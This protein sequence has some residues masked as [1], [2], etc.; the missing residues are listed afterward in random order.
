MTDGGEQLELL[1]T[2]SRKR[3]PKPPEPPADDDPVAGVVLDVSLPHLD[4]VFDYVVPA[5]MSD[6]AVPGARVRARFAG[7]EV[8]GFVVER[9]AATEHPGRLT[10]LRR[11]ASAEPVL[12][13]QVLAA[14]R[15]VA[16]ACAGT[17]A[18]VLR[19]AVP[20]RHAASEKAAPT[21]RRPLPSAPQPGPWRD[22]AGGEAFLA[23]VAAGSDPRAVWTAMPGRGHDGW[24]HAVAVATATALA[25]GRGTAIVV[26]D[27]RDAAR[28]DEALTDVLG[29]GRHVQLAADAGVGPRYRAFLALLRGSVRVVVGT[30]AAAFAPVADLGLV[31]CWDDGDDLHAEPRAPYPHTREVLAVRA[32]QEGAAFL[33]G[34]TSRT[35]EAQQL[36]DDGWAREVVAVR[37][38]VRRRAPRVVVAGDDEERDP[39]ARAARLPSLALRVTRSALERGPVLVQV[40]RA[41]YLPAL[42]CQTCRSPAR[43]A[44]CHGPLGL[45][46]GRATPA[47]RWCGRLAGGWTCP[48]CEGQRLRSVTVGSGRTAEELGR[49]FPGTTVRS[50][51][52][53]G[54]VLARVPDS[55]ALVV[56]TPG[57]EPV[58]AAGYAAGLLLD[59][60]APLA[61][62]DLRAAE[63]ALRRWLQA[64]SL[65]RGA[66]EGGDVVLVGDAGLSVVQAAVRW[67]PAGHAARELVERAELALPPA[68]AMAEVRGIPEGVEALLAAVRLPAGAQVLGPVPVE[69]PR[70][71]GD[72]VVRALVRAP[73][74]DAPALAAALAAARALLSARKHPAPPRVHTRPVEVA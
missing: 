52:G 61:R 14:A 41:G 44:A 26:P 23:R 20:P 3:R 73:L 32:E 8:D 72:P 70:Q 59:A 69:D 30:R 13:P 9:R 49:A 53:S 56:A 64:A 63:E 36:L 68:V 33:L 4:R 42:A 17:L 6:T 71:T 34:S 35:A 12:T 27:Y 11:V 18:D 28:V 39:A 60:W 45:A 24:P 66:A 62:P 67:D 22:Y 29:D 2:A 43:C 7:T 16:D 1:R 25:A 50:S 74:A 40:P 15:A 31:V 37:E 58:A 10:P 19:L 5:S 48:V 21:P 47:C 38:L 57:A 55:P 46:G 54:G 65:V 51:G